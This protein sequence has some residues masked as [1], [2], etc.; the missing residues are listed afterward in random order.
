MKYTYQ[1]VSDFFK[2]QNCQLLSKEYKNNRQK[3]DYICCCGNKSKITY[4]NFKKGIRCSICARN[5]KPPYQEVFN[6]FKSK[7]CQ[8]L[9]QEYLNAHQL[10]DYICCCGNK[11]KI[12]FNNFKRGQ[13]CKECKE[14]RKKQTSLK[15]YDVE[16][17]SQNPIIHEKQ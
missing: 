1:Y 9:T 6:Y 14:E 17:I 5:K 13:R 10:L 8:L 16:Y 4:A 15:K 11:S 2:S 12:N 7:N 3:L